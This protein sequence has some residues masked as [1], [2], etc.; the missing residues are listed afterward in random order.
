MTKGNSDWEYLLYRNNDGVMRWGV[1]IGGRGNGTVDG[2][3]TQTFSE[4]VTLKLKFE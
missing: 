2:V 1:R 3:V 4:K